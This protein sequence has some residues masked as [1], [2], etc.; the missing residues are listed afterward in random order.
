MEL[1]VDVGGVEVLAVLDDLDQHLVDGLEI[2]DG[3]ARGAF[4]A[5]KVIL[6]LVE[7]EAG[8]GEREGEVIAL[9]IPGQFA[10]GAH[11]TGDRDHGDEIALEVGQ[12]HRGV[13]QRFSL[14]VA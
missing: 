9:A 10:A 2:I 3:D 8:A 13:M 4:E 5:D 1:H 6:V 12:E 14:V 11:F 7:H